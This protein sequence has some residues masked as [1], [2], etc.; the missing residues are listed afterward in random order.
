M[1]GAVGEGAAAECSGF[2]R[3]YRKLPSLDGILADP[4]NALIPTD[5][6]ALYAVSIGLAGK[7]NENNFSRIVKYADRLHDDGHGEFAVLLVRD[8]IRRKSSLQNTP[9]F[10][11]LAASNIGKLFSG[12]EI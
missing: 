8:C 4:D 9:A 2:L 6:A 3:I 1:Q 7:A 10:V 11:Q 12:E 5:P